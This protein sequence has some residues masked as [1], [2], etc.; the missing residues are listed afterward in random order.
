MQAVREARLGR[1]RKCARGRWQVAGSGEELRLDRQQ[2]EPAAGRR[3]RLIGQ[4][5]VENRVRLVHPA[6]EAQAERQ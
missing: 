2:H 3:R 1:A 5:T 6:A 4:P